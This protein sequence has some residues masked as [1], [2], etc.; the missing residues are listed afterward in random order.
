MMCSTCSG[1]GV[2]DIPERI[3]KRTVKRSRYCDVGKLEYYEVEVVD[4]IGGIDACPH[5]AARAR[6]VWEQAIAE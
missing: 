1:S 6:S 2:V 3:V 4:R 5:C